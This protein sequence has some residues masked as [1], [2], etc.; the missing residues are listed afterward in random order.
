MDNAPASKGKPWLIPLVIG[1]LVA[2]VCGF[3]AWQYFRTKPPSRVILA[4]GTI[5]A[6][7][8]TIAPKVPGR[9]SVLNVNEGDNVKKGE[10]LAQLDPSELQAQLGQ[11][12]ANLFA[13]Q[14]KLDE[15]VNGNRPQQ[16]VQ[17][18]A[19]LEAARS[20]AT[21]S[22]RLLATN[23]QNFRTVLDLRS[24]LDVAQAKVPAMEAAY[25]QAVQALK[26]VLAGTRPLQ[27]EQAGAAVLQA[28]VVLK[29]ANLDEKRMKILADQGAI[30]VQNHDDALATRDADQS[31]FDQAQAHYSDLLVGSR[32][33]EVRQAQQEV[34]AAKA[35]LVGARTSFV[36]AMKMFNER[37][38]A[39]VQVETQSA[40][41]NVDIAQVAAAQAQF[42]LMRSGSRIEEI[43]AARAARDQARHAV[44]YEREMVADTKLYA[45]TGGVIKTRDSLLGETLSAGTPVVTI[46]DLDHI[47]I[48]VYVPEDK[49]GVLTLG[50]TVQLKVDSFP[51]DVFMGRIVSINSDAEFTPKNA[52]T[53]EE[54]VTLVFGVKIS[55]ENPNRRLK[56]GMPGDATIRIK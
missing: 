39:Q 9:L 41:T 2:A 42:D 13:A 49:Y 19:Q 43:N 40:T 8:T 3:F 33:E 21:G 24:Q 14:S 22:R 20:A 6:D 17:A 31:L 32:P 50:Q 15:A 48:R 7:E 37:L 4:S 46:A 10:L 53:T 34:A 44:D 30:A 11:A 29:K 45:P 12:D 54:R 5:E 25:R 23:R 35:N 18:M 52:Q 27:I 26:L 16:I 55:I 51:K 38:T 36:D 47:W 1:C 28:Q 56:P